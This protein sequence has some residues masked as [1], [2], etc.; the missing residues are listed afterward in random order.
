MPGFDGTGPLGMG[1]M[2]GR[3]MGYCAVGYPSYGRV[4][5][6]YGYAGMR[7]FPMAY[8]PNAVFRP[9]AT[10]WGGFGFGRG[11]RMGRGRRRWFPGYW[12]Y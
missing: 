12:Y 6:P 11:F 3:G 5:L 10:F 4:P 1:P 8:I 2:T 7:G 9:I